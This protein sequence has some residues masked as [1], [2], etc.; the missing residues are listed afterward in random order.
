MLLKY[1]V[2]ITSSIIFIIIPNI[3]YSTNN[4]TFDIWMV[5]IFGVV[6]YLFIKLGSEPAPL[7]TA[8]ASRVPDLDDPVWQRLMDGTL[9]LDVRVLGLQLLLS[10][11]R[12][13]VAMIA[14]EEVRRMK[15]RD[16]HRYFVK[17]ERM[18][19]YELGQLV[20]EAA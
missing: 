17:N 19:A 18:L 16:L 13:Q 10:R 14:D 6:G 11:T 20:R 3:T 15:L 12:S 9:P 7:P 8:A 1:W 4:N 2:I 5:A